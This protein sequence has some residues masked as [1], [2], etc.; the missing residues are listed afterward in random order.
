MNADDDRGRAGDGGEAGDPGD[1]R[2]DARLAALRKK[3]DDEKRR[4][5]ERQAAAR[6]SASGMGQALRLGSEF[7]AGVLVGFALGYGFDHVLGTTPWGMIVFLLLGFAAGTLNVLRAAGMVAE[8]DPSRL[9]R[10]GGDGAAGPG[11]TK[12]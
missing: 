1:G 11:D 2:I 4:G 8:H 10:P 6:G 12:G 7:V 5:D 9:K 3:L